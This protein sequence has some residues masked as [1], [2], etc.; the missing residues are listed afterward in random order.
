MSRTIWKYPIPITDAFTIDMPRGARI[1]SLDTQNGGPTIWALVD[2]AAEKVPRAFR[3][4]GTG[5]EVE[6]DTERADFIGTFQV[7]DG[8][9]V[10]HLFA[11][12]VA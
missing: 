2:P 6:I 3:L 9:L 1:L 8:A 5:H 12:K 7:S 10:F 11:R 4:F